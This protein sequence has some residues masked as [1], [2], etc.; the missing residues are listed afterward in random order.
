M[1]YYTTSNGPYSTAIG[2]QANALALN[3]IT[4][5]NQANVATVISNGSIAIG[6]SAKCLDS[7][8]VAIGQTSS[9]NRVSV[10]IGSNAKANWRSVSIGYNAQTGNDSVV[11]GDEIG[12]GFG[13][14]AASNNIIGIGRAAIQGENSIV[15]SPTS[16]SSN[17]PNSIAIGH[18][19]TS[20]ANFGLTLGYGCQVLG[21]NS[22]AIGVNPVVNV[23][24]SNSIAIGHCASVSANNIAGVVGGEIAIGAGANAILNSCIAIGN[25][26][27]AQL[28]Y[29][30]MM[31]AIAIGSNSSAT[32]S[33]GI[34]IGSN[35]TTSYGIAI[36]S[37]ATTSLSHGIAIGHNVLLYGVASDD[38]SIIMGYTSSINNSIGAKII[39]SYSSA[40][41]STSSIIIGEHTNL[42][43]N[44]QSGIFLGDL[45]VTNV[46]TIGSIGIGDSCITGATGSIAIGIQANS[47]GINSLAI[48]SQANAIGSNVITIG[49]NAT[50]NA[51]GGNTI[52]VGTNSLGS[53]VYAVALGCNSVASSGCGATA[54]GAYAY[55]NGASIAIG[56]RATASN[57]IGIG[58]IVIGQSTTSTT[59]NSIQLGSS[60]YTSIYWGSG[61]SASFNTTSDER[62]KENIVEANTT[63]CLSDVNRLKVKRFNYKDFVGSNTDKTVTG[64]IAQDFR[65][66][67]PKQVNEINKVYSQEGKEDIVFEDL[68]SID[69]SQVIYTLVGAIQELTKQNQDL[70]KRIEI[71]EN[72]IL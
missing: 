44:V 31:P 20:N 11:I 9:A 26:A 29:S 2:F 4:I 23:N 17:F 58:S 1:G 39:G 53:S 57:G 47:N 16:A 43:S 55:A 33:G 71:L 8:A 66:V 69:T 56:H 42:A 13:G 41:N 64:F 6:A 5:G 68:L 72:K 14:P 30:T 7:D 36:G 32:N 38:T 27:T 60:A 21:D 24:T 12:D 15:I 22:I 62:I 65:E 50:S 51:A 18:Y 46:N 3:S 70:T 37:N 59:A 63:I 34:A 45:I 61:T 28:Q 54:I 10:A 67:F 25:G 48:G 35:A 49:S 52:S 40:I 19:L